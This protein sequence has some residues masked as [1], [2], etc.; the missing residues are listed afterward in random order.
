MEEE[1]VF[2]D[3]YLQE[4]QCTR[5]SS[6]DQLIE[7]HLEHFF[8]CNE[9]LN[10]CGLEEDLS[11]R[12]AVSI[13]PRDVLDMLIKEDRGAYC[14][15]HIELQLS[16]L[17]S[18]GYEATRHR[19]HTMNCFLDA[20]DEEAFSKRD[21][22]R[23]THIV[24]VVRNK[25]KQYIVDVG[26]SKNA[27]RASLPVVLTLKKK[28]QQ[29]DGEDNVV[30]PDV[31]EVSCL[32]E[33]YRLSRVPGH[34]D[35]R[36]LDVLLDD[37]VWFALYRFSVVPISFSESVNLNNTMCC[38]Q[39]YTRIRDAIFYMTRTTPKKGRRLL[40]FVKEKSESETVAWWKVLQA[41]KVVESEKLTQ[42]EQLAKKAEQ[43]FG[44][45]PID[46]VRILFEKK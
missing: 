13:A 5:T 12:V 23:C 7:G 25:G 11:K 30:E 6:L 26:F 4:I 19:A 17:W 16:V 40:F 29:E 27:L 3:R 37:K 41:G 20:L 39:P 33:K 32:D 2:V 1:D 45:V 35:W 42:W 18:L 31:Q 24:L 38:A 28:T 9:K 15:Q 44:I 8:Y 43:E 36:Q 10:L 22:Q 21:D 34:P 46:N 14:F